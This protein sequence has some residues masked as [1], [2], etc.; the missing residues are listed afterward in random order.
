MSDSDHDH[1][2]ETE[3]VGVELRVFGGGAPAG[4]ERVADVEEVV[5]L[6]KDGVTGVRST[7][8]AEPGFDEPE[9]R[10]HH[11]S[12]RNHRIATLSMAGAACILVIGTVAF[13]MWKRGDKPGDRSAFD[14]IEMAPGE[15]GSAGDRFAKSTGRYYKEARE[16]LGSFLAAA[17]P[18]EAAKWVRGGEGMLEFIRRD[19]GAVQLSDDDIYRMKLK[20][21]DGAEGRQWISLDGKDGLRRNVEA[22]FVVNGDGLEFDWAATTGASELGLEELRSSEPGTE[23]LIRVVVSGDSFYNSTFPE[24]EVR[25]FEI[26]SASGLEVAWA[27]APKSSE[28]VRQIDEALHA[29]GTILTS[30]NSAKMTLR[31]RNSGSGTTGQFE[32]VDVVAKGWIIW[33]SP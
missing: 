17:T 32:L 31:V 11:K 22:V 21:H 10:K 7:D 29:D 3:D 9:P 18:E 16:I 23:A 14:I 30:E 8:E 15:A 33:E 20:V 24:E 5:R 2:P 25:C 28:V 12:R 27:Y 1:D 4:W 6:K 13:V 19:T 26:E